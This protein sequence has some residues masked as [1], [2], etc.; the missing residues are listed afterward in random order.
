[1]CELVDTSD[2]EIDEWMLL[3][4]H[5]GLLEAVLATWRIEGTGSP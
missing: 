4:D 1:M 2:R 5:M 3:K